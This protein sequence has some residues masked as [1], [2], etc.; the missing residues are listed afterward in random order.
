[1]MC[2][3]NWIPQVLSEE[4]YFHKGHVNHVKLHV[5]IDPER[6]NNNW[7]NDNT[8]NNLPKVV[9]EGIEKNNNKHCKR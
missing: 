1:M 4:V 2:N 7:A 5:T 6:N 9:T 8:G 3:V